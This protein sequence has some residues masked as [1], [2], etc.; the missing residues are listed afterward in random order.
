MCAVDDPIQERI[1]DRRI[2][3]RAVPGVN[4]QLARDERRVPDAPLVDDLEQLTRLAPAECGE[5]PVVEQQ[6]IGLAERA[7]EPRVGAVAFWPG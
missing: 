3:D 5:A 1:S 6:Q 2:G 4:G 7:H